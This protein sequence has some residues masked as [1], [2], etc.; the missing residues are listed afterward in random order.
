MIELSPDKFVWDKYKS[1]VDGGIA[2]SE[3]FQAFP[4]FKLKPDVKII[5]YCPSSQIRIRQ[6]AEGY[7]VMAQ[8]QGLEFWFHLQE[9]PK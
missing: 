8:W 1:K 5:G 4:S 3:I 6:R 2:D 9:L 7:V